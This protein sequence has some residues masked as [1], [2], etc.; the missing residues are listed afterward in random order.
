MKYFNW[1]TE[2]S[3]ALKALRGVCFEDIV[4]HLALGN[5]LADYQHPNQGKYKG[6][7]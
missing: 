1:N 3:R 7:G 2:K 4:F 5:L 6:R